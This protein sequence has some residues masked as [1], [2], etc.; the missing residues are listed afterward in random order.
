MQKTITPANCTIASNTL[1]NKDY[2]GFGE[3]I[4]IGGIPAKLLRKNITR[5]WEGESALLEKYLIIQ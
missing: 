2:S 5:D 4:I 1:C 3:N